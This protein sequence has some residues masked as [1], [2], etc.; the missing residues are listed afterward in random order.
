MAPREDIVEIMRIGHEIAMDRPSHE[1]AGARG[2][3]HIMDAL[4]LLVMI[5]RN[6]RATVK[7]TLELLNERSPQALR[8]LAYE[9]IAELHEL[10]WRATRPPAVP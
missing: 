9:A 1:G 3:R 2:M 4:E 6:E 10:R 5:P 7:E 8:R